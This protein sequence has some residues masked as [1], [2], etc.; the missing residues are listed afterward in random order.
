[1]HCRIQVIEEKSGNVNTLMLTDAKT[2]NNRESSS[3]ECFVKIE[4]YCINQRNSGM[5]VL[6]ETQHVKF[7]RAARADNPKRELSKCR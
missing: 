1:M 6:L 2:F 3:P 7:L 5:I 4:R